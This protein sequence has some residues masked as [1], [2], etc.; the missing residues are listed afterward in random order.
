MIQQME[1]SKEVKFQYITNLQIIRDIQAGK[2]KSPIAIPLETSLI[3]FLD[4]KGINTQIPT[5]TTGDFERREPINPNNIDLSKFD[6]TTNF[7]NGISQRHPL[8]AA[9]MQAVINPS[10]AKCL[11]ENGIIPLYHRYYSLEDQLN[12]VNQFKDKCFVTC[13]TRDPEQQIAN[14]RTLLDAGALGVYLDIT[15]GDSYGAYK[16]CE[17]IKKSHPEKKFGLGNL[18]TANAVMRAVN[19]GADSVKIGMGPGSPCTTRGITGV[20]EAQITA[21]VA[22]SLVARQF[23]IPVIA[24]GG[25]LDP[26]LA[27]LLGADCYMYGQEFCR[28][29]ESVAGRDTHDVRK[30]KDFDGMEVFYFGEASAEAKRRRECRNTKGTTPEGVGLWVPADRSVAG[31]IDRDERNIATILSCAGCH[32]IKELHALPVEKIEEVL[33]KLYVYNKE[34]LIPSKEDYHSI[35]TPSAIRRKETGFGI[36][37]LFTRYFYDREGVI[38]EITNIYKKLKVISPRLRIPLYD[39]KTYAQELL[40]EKNKVEK[41]EPSEIEDYSLCSRYAGSNCSSRMNT[42]CS[43]RLTKNIKLPSPFL[44]ANTNPD[45]ET[46]DYLKE[47]NLPRFYKLKNFLDLKTLDPNSFLILDCDSSIIEIQKMIGFYKNVGYCLEGKNIE[48]L[49]NVCI[50]ITNVF[51]KA[52][53]IA[54]VKSFE[55]AALMHYAGATGYLVKADKGNFGASRIASVATAGRIFKTPVIASANSIFTNESNIAIALGADVVMANIWRSADTDSFIDANE[56]YVAALR[57]SLTLQ[58]VLTIPELHKCAVVHR[59]S[60][61]YANERATRIL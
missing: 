39:I 46:L 55:E 34:P 26:G 4:E 45:Q 54:T 50:M 11:V 32:S 57:S 48:N 16:I 20:G 7:A 40:E 22:A 12:F 5:K 21:V 35:C 61:G 33:N 58:G 2:L 28:T 51:H 44:T 25:I 23:D 36:S 17:A 52:D 38:A 13:G 18:A 37:E 9:N 60:E 41:V 49:I 42:D 56:K 15:H 31:L 29:T 27:I 59:I 19:A 14:V 30:S 1:Q 6:F 3:K 24:D 8:V 10:L 53:I 47:N 43:T